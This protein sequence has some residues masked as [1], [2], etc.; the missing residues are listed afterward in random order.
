MEP[1]FERKPEKH[2]IG[3]KITMSFINNKT[4]LLWKGFMPRHKEIKNIANSNLYSIELYKPD[5][6]NPFSAD[7]EFEKWAAVEV[8]HVETVP[9]DMETIV[10][11]SGLYVVFILKGPAS[12]GPKIYEYVL[13]NWI[14]NS[15]YVLD[16]RP[17]FA[18]MGEKYRHDD[19]N[20]EEELWF[21]ILPKD[22]GVATGHH[23]D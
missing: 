15:A 19:P 23:R 1:R 21:P 3:M 4:G 11:P 6:F 7:T 20:S 17:H 14:P 9:A 22:Q 12:L 5:F 10:I 16:T 13:G 2:L 8:S 18:V